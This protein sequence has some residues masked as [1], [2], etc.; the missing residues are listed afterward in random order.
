MQGT[1][2]GERGTITLVRGVM[3]Q[4]ET[5][6][7]SF[8]GLTGALTTR[9]NGLDEQIADVDEESTKFSDRMDLLEERLRIQFAAADALISTLNNTSS[10]LDSQLANLPGYSRDN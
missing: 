1:D 4:V 5:F 3:N 10:F 6:L 2:V 8:T 9:V 7:R